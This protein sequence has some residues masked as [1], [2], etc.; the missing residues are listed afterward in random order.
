MMMTMMTMIMLLMITKIIIKSILISSSF[1]WSRVHLCST[2]SM[3]VH[4]Q[5]PQGEALFIS[6]FYM[7]HITPPYQHCS[8]F[9]L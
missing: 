7:I 8:N 4:F 6:I 3:S 5:E 2:F 1:D 9:L